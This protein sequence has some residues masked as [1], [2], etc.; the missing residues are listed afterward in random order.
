M[1]TVVKATKSETE[2]I[3]HS[4]S[5]NQDDRD[6]END[7]NSNKHE[8]ENA[9]KENLHLIS[10]SKVENFFQYIENKLNDDGNKFNLS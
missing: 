4:K 3:Q 1:D 6:S 5:Y 8:S 2:S 9:N 10:G 7:N